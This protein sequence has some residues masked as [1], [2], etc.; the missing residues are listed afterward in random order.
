MGQTQGGETDNHETVFSHPF[1]SVWSS[2][3]PYYFQSLTSTMI[4]S[5][6][7]WVKLP[8]VLNLASKNSDKI[9]LLPAQ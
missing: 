4:T 6:I 5:I 3:F 7:K 9:I 2:Q 8:S 1:F